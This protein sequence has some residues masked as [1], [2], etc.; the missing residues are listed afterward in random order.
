MLSTRLGMGLST[1]ILGLIVASTPACAQQKRKSSNEQLKLTAVADQEI[2]LRSGLSLD[3]NCEPY[4]MARV[5]IIRAPKNGSVTEEFRERYSS[6]GPNNP[7]KVCN[8]KKSKATYA[9]YRAKPGFQGT[10]R[11][12]FAIIYYDGKADVYDVE[13]TVWR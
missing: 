9:L 11:F 2:E 8:D 7:R 1:L 13:M 5:A 6:F 3:R 12:T 4:E 10:D